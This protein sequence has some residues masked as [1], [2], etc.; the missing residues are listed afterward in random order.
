MSSQFTLKE[1]RLY[2]RYL[3]RTQLLAILLP[4][5]FILGLSSGYLLWGRAA[6][7]AKA[8]QS[9]AGN[10]PTSGNQAA[11]NSG[12]Q[13]VKRYDVTFEDND[14]VLGPANAPVT[15][16]EF[17]DY[18]CPYC[19]KWYTEVFGRILSTYA[20]KVR[21]VYRDFPLTSLHP[22]AEPAAIAAHCA[23]EQGKYWEFHDLIFGGQLGLSATSY[24]Q[25][26]GNLNM[27]IEKFSTC[28]SSEKYK[29]EVESD[30]KYA[31]NL[32]V[33]STPTFFING[34]AVVGAQPFEVF[35][36]VIDQELGSQN[37]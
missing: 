26:A 33:R 10:Q 14:P 4:V 37:Q 17:S 6:G 18:Q 24:T 13:P 35:Q 20:N 19:R 36:Q 9:A 7:I 25:Y 34:I 23:G 29:A 31:S 11:A 15:I 21:F 22:E 30:L 27:N 1:K 3:K 5:A 8:Q 32:G 28:I 16:I 2:T 12:N